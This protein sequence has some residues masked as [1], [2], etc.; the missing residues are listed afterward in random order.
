MKNKKI[1]IFSIVALLVVFLAAI[2]AFNK[3]EEKKIEEIANKSTVGAPFVRE[4]SPQFGSNENNIVIVEFLDPQCEACAAFHP[5]IKK[6]FNEYEEETKLVI[7][8]LANHKNSKFTVRILEAARKQGKFNE[9]LEIIYKYQPQW[10]NRNNP[11]PQLLWNYLPQAGLD[12][13]KLKNDFESN[14]I[15]GL[16]SLDRNDAQTLNVLGTPS[17]YVNGKPL[18]RLS[19][20]SLLDLVES[21]IYK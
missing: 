16:L 19:Y 6:V 13:V 15:D 12:M 9:V 4:H 2:F 10:A 7:R 8:Y 11:Q 1:V 21:E 18:K 14:Y 20:Q 5:I 17:F 3:S